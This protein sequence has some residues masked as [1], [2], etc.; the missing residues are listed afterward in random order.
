VNEEQ[1]ARDA[2]NKGDAAER[3][4]R[5]PAVISALDGMRQKVYHN[6]ATSHHKQTEERETLYLMLKAIEG[7]ERE[8]KDAI[9]GGKKAKSRL[10]NLFKGG[11]DGS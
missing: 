6:I 2:I 8:F 4:M 5:D 1:R 11:Q 9:N 10:L 3:I 7:F